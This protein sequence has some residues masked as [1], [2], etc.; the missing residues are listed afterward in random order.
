MIP[1]FQPKT[2]H[3]NGVDLHYV[4]QGTG[5]AVVLVHGGGATDYRTWG[6][7]LDPFAQR[8]HVVAYSLR[9]H[10]PNAW[11]GNGSDYSTRVH[12]RDLA[13]LIEQLKL[14]PAHVVASSFGGDVALRTAREQPELIRSLVLAEP[15]LDA[16][17]NRLLPHDAA[18]GEAARFS[19]AESA[20]AVSSGDIEGGVRL[21]ARRVLGE[22]AYDRLPETVRQRMRDN[23]RL[24]TLPEDVFLS[25]FTC[26]D[27]RMIQAPTLLLVGDRSPK[28]F[29]VVAD[30]LAACLGNLERATIPNAAHLLHGMNPGVFNDAVLGFLGRH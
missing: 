6:P 4:E 20:Q 11:A 17:R 3:V 26:D 25:D 15:A 27:A 7:Q 21:F 24:L 23:V 19:W 18:A 9:Y 29:L 10:Y 8:Y 22:G 13:A 2:V 30:A 12:A 1:P 28:Q 14:A 5:E 16:W